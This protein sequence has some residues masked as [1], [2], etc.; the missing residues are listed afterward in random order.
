MPLQVPELNGQA[1]VSW[2]SLVVEWRPPELSASLS[3][4]ANLRDPKIFLVDALAGNL[5]C[6]G[7]APDLITGVVP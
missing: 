6:P 2:W 4:P 3:P 7:L 5:H 1:T